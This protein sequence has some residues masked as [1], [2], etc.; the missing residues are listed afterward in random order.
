MTTRDAVLAALRVAGPGGVSGEALARELGVSRVAVGKHVAV[1]RDAGYEI[2]A[3]PGVGYRLLAV[4]DA[5]LPSEVTRL[6][7]SEFWSDLRGGGETVSTNDDARS[8]ARAGAPEGTV[9]LADRQTGGRGRLGRSWESPEGGAYV[10]AVLRPAVA[11]AEVGSLALAVGLGIARGLEGEFGLDTQLKWPNDVLLSGRKLAGILLEMAAETDRV[12]WV[13]AGVGI[14]VHRAAGL[15]DTA[16][17]L[18]DVDPGVRVAPAVAALLDGIAN[19]YGEWL[20]GGFSAIRD[21]YERRLGILGD[22][23][24]VRDMTGAIRAAGIVRGV[25]DQGRLRVDDGSRIQAI[26][27]GEVTLRQP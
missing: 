7:H 24:T 4:P 17:C 6:L 25:D 15:P 18:D 2:T 9:V 13:V 23:V 20:G 16:A 22:E 1:L 8:L 21:D 26:S 12:D 14:N 3:E 27:A 11:P 5:P 10:S 19:A